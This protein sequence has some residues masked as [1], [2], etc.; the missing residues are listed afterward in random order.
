MLSGDI[1]A[2]KGLRVVDITVY[3]F[4]GA[5]M[6][7][8]IGLTG[9]GGGVL[10]VPVLI[11]AMRLEPIEAVGTASLYAV[12]TKI[13]AAIRH[14]RQD[15]LNIGIGIRFLGVSLPGVVLGALAIKW[16]KIGL[17]PAGVEALQQIVSDLVLACIF[18]ALG[19]MLIDYRRLDDSPAGVPWRKGIQFACAFSIGLVM[20][21]TA[22]GGGILIIPALIVFYRE[23]SK[24]VGTSIFIGLCSMAVMSS[25]YAIIGGAT[26]GGDVNLKAA[27]FMAAGA[28]AATHHGAS[29]SKKIK[30]RRLR[31]VVIAVI[32]LAIVM[33]LID[34]V[35]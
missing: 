29:L 31:T 32:V 14:Y 1:T 24:Y 17:S 19:V 8:L 11:L 20:G 21:S 30:P 13:W 4:S 18:A 33:M 12:L 6:G 10:A 16:T 28:L 25:L 23:T 9:V 35:L 22:I 15:T 5:V 27:A 3:V 2:G 7:F 34:R 26:H